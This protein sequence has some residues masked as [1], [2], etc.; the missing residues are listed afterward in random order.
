[1]QNQ[2]KKHIMKKAFVFASIFLT[3]L[4]SA[5]MLIWLSRA[6]P[7]EKPQPDRLLP[8]L[9]L[10]SKVNATQFNAFLLHCNTERLNSL[11]GAL[12]KKKDG[13]SSAVEQIRREFLWKSSHWLPYLKK[14]K[15]NIPYH[16]IVCW[17]AREQGVSDADLNQ[18]PTFALERKIFERVFAQAWDKLT[19]AQ[20]REAISK[21]KVEQS[22]WQGIAGMSGAAAIATLSTTTALSGFAFYTGMSS[23][24]AS[25]AQVLAISLPFG[26]YT[27]GSAI[28]SIASGPVGWVVGA[29]ALGAGATF[30]GRANP[31]ATS[32]MIIQIHCI[33]I[34]ALKKSGMQ[35]P[36]L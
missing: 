30:T 13:K 32:Q 5:G 36:K 28:V 16:D 14:D 35:L 17:A 23:L 22:Q 21:M 3:L 11:L 7:K 4:I 24:L 19:P 2:R 20:R 31:M 6:E 27:T 10:D 29:V 26:A 18:L 9:F 15:E 34:D 12:E 8:Y 25:T 33:K 1:M